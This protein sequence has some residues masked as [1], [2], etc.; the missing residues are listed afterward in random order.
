MTVNEA[1]GN[2][3]ARLDSQTLAELTRRV[4]R[5]GQEFDDASKERAAAIVRRADAAM[6][7]A[8][9][10]RDGFRSTPAAVRRY[11]DA[12]AALGEAQ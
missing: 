1:K 10:A 6:Q 4:E 12:I 7:L 5:A 9:D 2:L 8:N 11:E 3:Q